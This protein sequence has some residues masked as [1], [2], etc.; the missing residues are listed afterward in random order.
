[1]DTFQNND[2]SASHQHQSSGTL[3]LEF[4][5]SGSEYFRIW[6]VNLLLTIITLGIYSAWAKVRRNRYLYSSTQLGGSSFEYHG[7][8][9]AILKGRIVAFVFIFGYQLAFK[10]SIGLGFA[11]MALMVAIMPWLV[12]K[13]LQF[14]LY[15]SSYRGIRF[16]FRGTAG[17]AYTTF[18]LW[19]FLTGLSLYLLAPVFHQRLKQFQHNESRFG[20]THFSF[21]AGVGQFYKAYLLGIGIMI[22]GVIVICVGFGSTVAALAAVASNSDGHGRPGSVFGAVSSMFLFMFVLY[23]WLFA[24]YPIFLTLLQNLIWNHTK[25]GEHQFKNN[26]VWSRMSFIAVTNVL[27]I[28]CTLGLFIPFAQIR[29]LRYRIESLELEVNG[30]L[31]NF[32]AETQEQVNAAGEGMADLLD[33]DLSL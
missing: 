5:G 30:S 20:S 8:A 23:L 9:I 2:F 7:N 26:M 25:L 1:M 31:D 22:V 27:A 10:F 14:K 11:M 19:P 13:S 29:A 32:I 16:G 18:L 28:V 21:D 4:K 12:W 3:Q 15:N 24:I 33:F 6:I 17:Q